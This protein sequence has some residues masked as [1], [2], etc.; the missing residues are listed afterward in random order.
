MTLL[1]NQLVSAGMVERKPG[2]DDRRVS[3]I[4]LTAR[5]RTT[6][7]QLAGILK[8]NVREKL[9]L[10]TEEELSLLLSRLRKLGARLDD[11]GH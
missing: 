7:S 9:S 11:H 5:G 10:L 6:V 3:E 2:H 8:N 1:I 4:T